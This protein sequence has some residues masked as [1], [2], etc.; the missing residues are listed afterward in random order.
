M[1][2]RS[3]VKTI[4]TMP[5][6]ETVLYQPIFSNTQLAGM[7]KTI[8]QPIMIMVS[9]LMAASPLAASWKP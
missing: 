6:I 5:A 9:A 3:R 4:N 7:E 2:P 1:K 8:M